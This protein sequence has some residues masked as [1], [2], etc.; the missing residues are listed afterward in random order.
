MSNRSN[1]V[2]IASRGGEVKSL[3]RVALDQVTVIRS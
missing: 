1:H 3:A 2:A